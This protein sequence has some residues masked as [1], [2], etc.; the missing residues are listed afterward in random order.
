MMA[1]QN[2]DGQRRTYHA[3]MPVRIPRTPI[4]RMTPAMVRFNGYS[5]GF[6]A[7]ISPR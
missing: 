5:C 7:M 6:F 2:I 4:Q 1:Y 3:L